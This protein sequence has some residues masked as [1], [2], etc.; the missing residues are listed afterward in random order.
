MISFI[1]EKEGVLKFNQL[2]ALCDDVPELWL[3][4]FHSMHGVN[5]KIP[6]VIVHKKIKNS[7]LLVKPRSVKYSVSMEYSK[8]KVGLYLNIMGLVMQLLLQTN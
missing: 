6:T 8:K 7:L 5:D 3:N 4:G 1:G 2:G